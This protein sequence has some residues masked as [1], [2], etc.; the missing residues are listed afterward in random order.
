VRDFQEY[1]LPKRWG[2]KTSTIL[3]AKISRHHW[4]KSQIVVSLHNQKIADKKTGEAGDT[5]AS[6]EHN[7]HY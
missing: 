1:L 4:K 5:V 6:F 2:V 3:S 7:T